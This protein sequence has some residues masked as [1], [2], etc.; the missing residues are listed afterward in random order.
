MK[1]VRCENE[2]KGNRYKNEMG[3]KKGYRGHRP[4]EGCRI[5]N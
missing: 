5:G 1:G 3:E 2:M 4:L